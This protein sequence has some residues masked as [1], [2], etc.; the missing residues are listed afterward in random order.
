MLCTWAHC[1][2]FL[3]NIEP[4]IMR[5]IK[6]ATPPPWETQL[7]LAL[8]FFM[9]YHQLWCLSYPQSAAWEF[10]GYPKGFDAPYKNIFCLFLSLLPSHSAQNSW[11]GQ[12]NVYSWD[13]KVS[14]GEWMWKLGSFSSM[15][16]LEKPRTW[17]QLQGMIGGEGRMREN[18]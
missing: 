13:A 1:V 10:W 2:V 11:E 12:N 8:T 3:S 6:E 9:G 17:W 14:Y 18:L 16:T 4:E 5:I 7:L 15:K